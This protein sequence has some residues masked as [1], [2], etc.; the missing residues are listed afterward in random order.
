V[1]GLGFEVI[2]TPFR[3]QKRIRFAKG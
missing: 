3:A 1:A 2:K